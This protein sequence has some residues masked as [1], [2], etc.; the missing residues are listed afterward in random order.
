M[1]KFTGENC[2]FL[3]NYSRNQII[4]ENKIPKLVSDDFTIEVETY[5]DWKKCI[6]K[7]D[8]KN[9]FEL[10][11]TTFNGMPF[12]IVLRKAWPEFGKPDTPVVSAT[13][14]I[15]GKDKLEPVYCDVLV[16]EKFKGISKIKMNYVKNK[17]L[18]LIVNDKSNKIELQSSIADYSESWLWVG[19]CSGFPFTPTEHQGF[20]E[21]E[22]N[23]LKIST[24]DY[25]FLD[26]DFSMTNGRKIFD[27][28]DFGHH[29][30]NRYLNKENSVVVF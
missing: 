23:S 7:M 3:P 27:D 13:V 8:Y 28:T 2:F 15:Q 6:K 22:I 24:N 1:I 12:G 30:L 5:I 16:S 19:C 20:F 26:C 21:G 14:W 18:E 4:N 17:S 25:D 29:L 10:G 9:H 11:I